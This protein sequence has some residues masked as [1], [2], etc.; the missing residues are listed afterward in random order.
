MTQPPP[1]PLPT[2]GSNKKSEATA[3]PLSS[4][5]PHSFK[6]LV[7]MKAQEMNVEFY[8]VS[9]RTHEARQVCAPNICMLNKA[10]VFTDTCYR[11]IHA[12]HAI[13]VI[14]TC[15]AWKLGTIF[16]QMVLYLL[17]IYTYI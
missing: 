12:I 8:P 6:D 10:S 5:V 9:G 11:P 17:T 14:F 7:A 13:M 3:P 16:I 2:A 4:S 15:N 1:P